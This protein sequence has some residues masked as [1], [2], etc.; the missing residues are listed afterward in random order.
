MY[1]V[2]LRMQ[3]VGAVLR[4]MLMV[5]TV[6]AWVLVGG[7]MRTTAV[8]GELGSAEARVGAPE[9]G[10]R[11]V[12]VLRL[13]TSSPD[14][15]MPAARMV[16]AAAWHGGSTSQCQ[17]VHAQQSNVKAMC[18]GLKS[19]RPALQAAQ[20]PPHAHR[21]CQLPGCTTTLAVK[22]PL[23]RAPGQRWGWR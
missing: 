15:V 16:S 12:T 7:A 3:L 6:L 19:V 23:E 1:G 14:K 18:H 13:G 22:Q 17:R 8:S 9:S 20:E 5:Y 21:W 2:L 11:M 10:V 4:Q